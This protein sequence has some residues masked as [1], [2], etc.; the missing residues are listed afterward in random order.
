MTNEE[1]VIELLRTNDSILNALLTE[2]IKLIAQLTRESLHTNREAFR[3]FFTTPETYEKLCSNIENI[4]KED[5]K[6]KHSQYIL[7]ME[8]EEF[9][10]YETEVKSEDLTALFKIWEEKDMTNFELYE[11]DSMAP[12]LKLLDKAGMYHEWVYIYPEQLEALKAANLI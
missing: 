6:P 12:A 7:F 8:E 11:V 1:S 3:T 10:I 2:R 9:E 5:Y 4:F